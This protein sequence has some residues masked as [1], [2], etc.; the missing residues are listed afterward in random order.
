MNKKTLSKYILSC[1]LAFTIVFNLIGHQQHV[2]AAENS[3]LPFTIVP[4]FPENQ[5]KNVSQ[6]LSITSKNGIHQQLSFE[7]LNNTKTKKQVTMKVLNAYTSPNG[8]IQ[9][10]TKKTD[11]AVIIDQKYEM[12]KYAKIPKSITV[13]PGQ[14]KKVKVDI[15]I[16]KVEA[17]V[18]GGVAFQIV[19]EPK[20][21]ESNKNGA[22]FALKNKVNTIYGIAVHSS[23]IQ[24]AKFSFGNV[25]VDPMATYYAVRLPIT[26]HSPLIVQN[27]DINYQVSYKGKKLFFAKKSIK[28]AP[29]T[30]TNFSIPFDYDKI[31]PGT[32]ILKGTLTYKDEKGNKHIQNFKREFKYEKD[33]TNNITNT[34]K[35]PFDNTHSWLLYILLFILLLLLILFILFLRKKKKEKDAEEAVKQ[36][37]ETLLKKDYDIAQY[38]VNNLSKRSN[39][40]ELLQIRLN[41]VKEAIQK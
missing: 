16:P 30:K 26:L 35:A 41:A 5:D 23:K 27:G 19:K 8:I 34:L 20:K 17:S 24:K 1:F 22:T 18:L 4:I 36:A 10:E 12:K 6:Y 31:E 38:L 7:L 29:M 13:N 11:D 33:H 37:E 40:R 21:Q 3:K 9:Y 14:I 39:K 32:Y 25:Y 28:F 15:N 2:N